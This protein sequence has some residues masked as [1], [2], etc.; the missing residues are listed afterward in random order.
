MVL[1]APGQ[2]RFAHV[3]GGL[4]QHDCLPRFGA[5]Q[6]LKAKEFAFLVNK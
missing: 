1:H 6:F 5:Q 2:P 3:L 4:D